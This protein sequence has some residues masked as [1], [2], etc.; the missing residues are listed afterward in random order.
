MTKMKLSVACVC[1]LLLVG[2]ITT[3]VT[4]LTPTEV[5][6]N[7]S[8]QYLIEYAW[9]SNQQTV[10]PETIRPFVVVGFDTYEMKRVL[11]MTN[12][13]ETYVPVPASQ[14]SLRYHFKVDYDYSQFGKEPG[15]AS[16]I[17]PEYKLNIVER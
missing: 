5:P 2:C 8:G 16:I 13:W 4:N 10:R 3:T 11:R 7:P 17:S 14:N 9:Q 1:G 6:R 15:K 12:R